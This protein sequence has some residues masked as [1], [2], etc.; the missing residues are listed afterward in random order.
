VVVVLVVLIAS[1]A[2]YAVFP[3]S[4]RWYLGTLLTT[5]VGVGA[6]QA[7]DALGLPSARFGGAN[8]LPALLFAVALQPVVSRLP[9]RAAP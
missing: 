2:L 7:W 5:A 9:R 1:Q 3:Y 4:R 8:L 6:G